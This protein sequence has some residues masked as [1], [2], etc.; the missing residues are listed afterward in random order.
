M[1]FPVGLKVLGQMLD[2]V[3]EKCDLHIRAP[4]IFFMQLELR[5]GCRLIA[6]CH[7]EAG[8]LDEDR[9]LATAANS[10]ALQTSFP[11]RISFPFSVVPKV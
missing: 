6:L 2:P 11:C 3:G 7:N 1:I 5:K 4:R 8:N 9:G 10:L